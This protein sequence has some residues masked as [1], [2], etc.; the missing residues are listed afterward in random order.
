MSAQSRN[1]TKVV[2][3][4][5]IDSNISLVVSKKRSNSYKKHCAKLRTDLVKIRLKYIKLAKNV[6]AQSN[7]K[8]ESYISAQ[9]DLYNPFGLNKTYIYAAI[10]T[11]NTVPNYARIWLKIRTNYS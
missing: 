4:K 3:H 11:G 6:S 10:L 7:L 9:T 2:I 8:K 1:L 5:C